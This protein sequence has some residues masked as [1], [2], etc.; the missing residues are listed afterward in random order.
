MF[1]GKL[2]RLGHVLHMD[3]ESRCPV[4][5]LSDF[6]FVCVFERRVLTQRMDDFCKV[7]G[8]KYEQYKYI[9]VIYGSGFGA[10]VLGATAWVGRGT[11]AQFVNENAVHMWQV[12]KLEQ[13]VGGEVMHRTYIFVRIECF[14][15]RWRWV[16]HVASL[17]ENFPPVSCY[18]NVIVLVIERHTLSPYR[19]E[20]SAD[21]CVL[22][23]RETQAISNYILSTRA[24]THTH[25][26]ILR[27]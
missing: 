7:G 3:D 10:T 21:S 27:T 26:S 16:T 20:K 11:F 13:K 2:R 6:F 22:E 5:R 4:V 15:A 18:M 9:V 25:T 12:P 8:S 19:F 14:I 1:K 17:S 23:L 24:I